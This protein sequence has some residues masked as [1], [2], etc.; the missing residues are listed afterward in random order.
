DQPCSL[1]R[2]KH[3]LGSCGRA[4]RPAVEKHLPDALPAG[5]FHRLVEALRHRRLHLLL[6]AAHRIGVR[7]IPA[8]VEIVQDITHETSYR[9]SVAT[10]HPRADRNGPEKAFGPK[11]F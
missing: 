9:R 11:T 10:G 5:D 3:H 1:L 2:W 6:R 8:V 7:K 4:D